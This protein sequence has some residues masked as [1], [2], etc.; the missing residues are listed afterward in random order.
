MAKVMKTRKGYNS[1]ARCV[2]RLLIDKPENR[3]KVT[4]LKSGHLG[5]KS[6]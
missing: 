4:R 2:L 6:K 3:S 1:E 5:L